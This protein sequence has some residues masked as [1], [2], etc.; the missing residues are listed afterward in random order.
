MNHRLRFCDRWALID[1]YDEIGKLINCKTQVTLLSLI[2]G[3]IEKTNATSANRQGNPHR[4]YGLVLKKICNYF[5]SCCGD[6]YHHF[7]P[8]S[9]WDRQTLLFAVLSLPRPM[10]VGFGIYVFHSALAHLRRYACFLL[11]R[12]LH[13]KLH[14]I[15]VVVK[16]ARVVRRP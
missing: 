6:V 7:S 4:A 16:T 3:T 15:P 5:S 14:E 9:L 1:A 12:I 10:S 11:Y 2:W 13:F 8:V